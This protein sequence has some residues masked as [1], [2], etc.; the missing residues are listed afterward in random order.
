MALDPETG[1]EE[2]ILRPNT[3]VKMLRVHD[4]VLYYTAYTSQRGFANTANNAFG[5]LY[6]LRSYDLSTGREEKIYEGRIRAFEHLPSGSFLLSVDHPTKP[7]SELIVVNTEGGIELLV[8]TGGLLVG[9]IVISSNGEVYAVARRQGE[10]WDIYKAISGYLLSKWKNLTNTPWAETGLSINQDGDLLYSANPDG[11]DGRVGIYLYDPSEQAI[12]KVR[13]PSYAVLPVMVGNQIIFTSLNPSGYDLYSVPLE[14]SSAEFSSLPPDTAGVTVWRGKIITYDKGF[15]SRSSL[16]PYLSLFR[17]WARIP[18][19]WPSFND[20]W[21]LTNLDMGIFLL[22]A[23]V[24]GEN[25]YQ[26]NV[27]CDAVTNTNTVDFAWGNQR[28]APLRLNLDYSHNPMWDTEG[29]F[30][31]YYYRIY[32]SFNYPL[33]YRSGR[34]LNVIRWGEGFRTTGETLQNR[35]LVSNLGISFSW[36]F[37]RIGIAASHQWSSP[38]FSANERSWLFTRAAAVFDLAGGLLLADVFTFAD[39]SAQLPVGYTHSAP[40]RGYAEIETAD[41]VFSTATLE[42]R[43]RLLKMRFG[44][45]NPNVFFEDLYVNVFTDAAFDSRNLLGASVGLELSPEIHLS[46]GFLRLAPIFGVSLN[47]D[48]KIKPHF[49]V[50]TAL[51]ISLL[52]PRKDAVEFAADPWLLTLNSTEAELSEPH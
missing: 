45:W 48:R 11:T 12:E 51:P 7:W 40:I 43:H 13:A 25:F 23:D 30:L 42:Y 46:W 15:I 29:Q 24:L 1:E 8:G 22:G 52:N 50:W 28:F 47:I 39:L 9:E 32:P 27:S 18:Y 17:P 3:S 19:V 6:Q 2:V 33:Y 49:G 38:I 10:H 35:T 44:L 16:S 21:D 36:P 37:W 20:A 26:A 41:P 4:G 14:T 34:G 31:G 5:E